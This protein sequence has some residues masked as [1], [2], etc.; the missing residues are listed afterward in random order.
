MQIEL[1]NSERIIGNTMPKIFGI[2][3]EEIL[4]EVAST[5]A[6]AVAGFA[7]GTLGASVAGLTGAVAT[8]GPIG[9]GILGGV[10]GF[11]IF[12]KS[13]GG[14]GLFKRTGDL[15]AKIFPKSCCSYKR[16]KLDLK[17]IEKKESWVGNVLKL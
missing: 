5:G 9:L 7:G 13:L 17:D 2:V 16:K 4:K 8:L 12:R 6:G 3:L 15:L 1:K 11:F 14:E 10:A